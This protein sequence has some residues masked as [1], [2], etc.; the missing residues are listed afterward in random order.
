MDSPGWSSHLSP[1]EGAVGPKGRQGLPLPTQDN[2]LDFLE[3]AAGL[4][5]VLRGS[6][7]TRP[8]W[9]FK[10]CDDD[11]NGCV[12][13][14]VEA[15]YKLKKTRWGEMEA[16][17]HKQLLRPEE[18]EDR[19]FLPVDGKGDGQL[20]LDEYIEGACRDKWA[21]KMLHMDTH[22]GGWISQQRQKSA[23]FRGVWGPGGRGGVLS[24]LGDSRLTQVFR[25][26]KWPSL[27]PCSCPHLSG[28]DF[29]LCT[30]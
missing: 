21:M 6:R 8:R 26:V 9:T 14:L 17:Q 5:L 18:V 22:P 15:I 19:V 30:Q 7:S 28:L 24:L 16:E 11:R 12:N 2:T 4:P 13:H 27:G 25:V 29:A 1:G 20:S 10:I 3:K 23:M